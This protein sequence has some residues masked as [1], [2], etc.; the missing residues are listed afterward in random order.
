V[1]EPAAE[2]ILSSQPADPVL[3]EA[4]FSRSA[5][6]GLAT[7]RALY[8]RLL[9]CRRL[10]RAWD[11]VGKYL[12]RT[13]TQLARASDAADLARRLSRLEAR[14]QDFPPLLGQAGQPG[15]RV[16]VL[17]RDDQPARAFKALSLAERQ[18][19]AL[20][21]K[22]SRTMLLAHQQYVRKVV[23]GLRRQGWLGRAVR[24]VRVTLND[25]PAWALL[26]TLVAFLILVIVAFVANS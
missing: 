26:G 5:R 17:A 23:R 14:L 16:L 1:P 7:R 24:A 9:A 2:P 4:R 22:V 15:Y 11:L 3:E 21:W 13:K 18:A 6:R 19:L 20:D 10:L 25:H 8:E 12:T